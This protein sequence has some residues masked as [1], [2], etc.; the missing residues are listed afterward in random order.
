M[1]GW[2]WNMVKTFNKQKGVLP[3]SDE[4]KVSYLSLLLNGK[5]GFIIILRPPGIYARNAAG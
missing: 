2:A 5:F 3:V 1:V 4:T